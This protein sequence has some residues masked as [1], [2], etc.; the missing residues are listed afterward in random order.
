MLRGWIGGRLGL[1]TALLRRGLRGGWGLRR[2]WLRRSAALM[3]RRTR[4]RLRSDTL[5]FVDIGRLCRGTL[6]RVGLARLARSTTSMLGLLSLLRLNLLRLL[7]G[8][9]LL[10]LRRHRLTV[11]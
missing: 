1:D 5:R 6:W 4:L 8:Q 3:R 10:L 2:V 9:K 7:E 11:R